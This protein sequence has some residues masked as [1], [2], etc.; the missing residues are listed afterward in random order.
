MKLQYFGDSQDSFKWDYHD[1][2]T[3]IL[4]FETLNILLM[5]TPDDGTSAGSTKPTL[6]PARSEIIEFCNKIKE[7]QDVN[8]LEDLPLFLDSN[9]KVHLHEKN[10]SF[11]NREKYFSG[12]K[13]I[14]NQVIFVDPDNGFEP[15]KK[16]SSKHIRYKELSMIL[17]QITEN[18]VISVFQHF[19][20]ISFIEDFNK[21]QN[22]ILDY[23][24]SAKIAAIYWHKLMFVLITKSEETYNKIVQANIEYARRCPVKNIN[25]R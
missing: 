18:S 25:F 15:S 2:L 9:Y 21:I 23:I 14:E 11:L 19:R 8:L 10:N 5:L 3:D 12:I 1:Y 4:G 20:R 22:Q 17:H 24:P 16:Y 7:I 13:N 6:F